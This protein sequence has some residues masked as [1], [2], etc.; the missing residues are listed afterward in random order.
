MLN[1]SDK[2]GMASLYLQ[3]MHM[4]VEVKQMNFLSFATHNASLK[5][6][7]E[8]ARQLALIVCPTYCEENVHWKRVIK[9]MSQ[10]AYF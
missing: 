4:K 2:I 3:R 5:S 9:L 1:T 7:I 8:P 6:Q 10:H